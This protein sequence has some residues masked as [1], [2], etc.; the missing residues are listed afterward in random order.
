MWA[1]RWV[2]CGGIKVAF[3]LVQAE[4]KLLKHWK[5][6]F[7]ISFPIPINYINVNLVNNPS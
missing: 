4:R 3:C 6:L 1:D 2:A 5:E 7:P